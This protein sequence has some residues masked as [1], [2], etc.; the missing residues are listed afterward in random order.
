IVKAGF[1]LSASTIEPLFESLALK[2][3]RLLRS[4]YSFDEFLDEVVKSEHALVTAN[5][6]K[7]RIQFKMNACETEY[8]AVTINGLRRHTVAVEGSD[9]D[10]VLSLIQQLGIEQIQNTSYIHEIKHLLLDPN[11]RLRS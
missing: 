11:P 9:L 1:P 7:E 4:N 10:S 3:P 5:V 2:P 8:A 6:S